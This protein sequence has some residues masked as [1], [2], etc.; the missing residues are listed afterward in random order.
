MTLTN[1]PAALGQSRSSPAAWEEGAGAAVAARDAP[2]RHSA[3]E[4]AAAGGAVER[5]VADEDVLL[6][7][8]RGP[9]GRIDDYL[10]AGEPLGDVIIGVALQPEGDAGRQEGAE[11]L[12]G[13]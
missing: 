3:G 10:A 9:P 11:A 13:G 8:E 7:H 2:P 6:R 4:Q 1:L 5:D 12:A